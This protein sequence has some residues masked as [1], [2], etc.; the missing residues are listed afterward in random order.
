MLDWLQNNDQF[1]KLEEGKLKGKKNRRMII[2][3]IRYWKPMSLT[4]RV[5]SWFKIALSFGVVREWAKAWATLGFRKAK[6]SSVIGLSSYMRRGKTQKKLSESISERPPISLEGVWRGV[7]PQRSPSTSNSMS[8]EEVGGR[9]T[10]LSPHWLDSFAATSKDWQ[11]ERFLQKTSH[12][13]RHPQQKW[14]LSD[15]AYES[16]K[17]PFAS[18]LAGQLSSLR[19]RTVLHHL[20]FFPQH[21]LLKGF[22]SHVV[23]SFVFLRS[24]GR[25]LYAKSFCSLY[26]HLSSLLDRLTEEVIAKNWINFFFFF[27]AFTGS[28]SWSFVTSPTPP[29]PSAKNASISGASFVLEWPSPSGLE[30]ETTSPLDFFARGTAIGISVSVAVSAE[31]P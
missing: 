16:E 28:A 14:P 18:S 9:V 10:P 13:S 22:E 11:Y 26:D 17:R 19:Q 3:P 8:F 7:A 20:T 15:G 27:V 29:N 4:S 31:D 30:T 2:T 25:R 6:S 24:R 1:W 12:P 23:S 21:D 5:L